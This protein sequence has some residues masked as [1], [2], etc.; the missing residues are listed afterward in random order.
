MWLE[1]VSSGHVDSRFWYREQLRAPILKRLI[2]LFFSYSETI[3]ATYI[4]NVLSYYIDSRLKQCLLPEKKSDSFNSTAATR[5]LRVK[6]IPLPRKST[7]TF[8]IYGINT[9]FK[10]KI[11]YH[12]IILGKLL[13]IY[14]SCLPNGL[15]TFPIYLS[16]RVKPSR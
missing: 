12:S 13:C 10:V 14:R 9:L 2:C 4:S 7:S 1:N 6:P 3:N 15:N 16:N 8:W 5:I 11:K